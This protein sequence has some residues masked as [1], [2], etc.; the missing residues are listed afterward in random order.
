MSKISRDKGAEREHQSVGESGERDISPFPVFLVIT[1]LFICLS[2]VCSVPEVV[3]AL[4]CRLLV[5]DF[6][7]AQRNV[8]L[9]F[10]PI[11]S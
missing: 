4:V 5:N 7:S 6:F 1:D 11:S 9:F 2:S 3:A 8:F 10:D